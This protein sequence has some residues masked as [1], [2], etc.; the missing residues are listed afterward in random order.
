MPDI[1]RYAAFISYSSKDS[2]FA[3]RLHRKLEYYRIPHTLGEFSI[4]G[5]RNRIS[6]I[7]IDRAELPSGDLGEAIEAALR[8]SSA[9]IVVCS[10]NAAES[11]WVDKEIRY[12]RSLNRQNRIFAIIA[13]GEPNASLNGSPEIECFPPSL[14]DFLGGPDSGS[15]IVAGDARSGKDGFRNAWLKIV[16]GILGVNLGSLID[17]DREAIRRFRVILAL[18]ASAVFASALCG[19]LTYQEISDTAAMR[20]QA[21]LLIL[22]GRPIVAAPYAVAGL[23]SSSMVMGLIPNPEAEAVLQD[24]GMVLRL[25]LHI[26]GVFSAK[27]HTLSG[28]GRRLLTKN[29]DGHGSLYDTTTG[30]KLADLGR[31]LTWGMSE[32]GEYATIRYPDYSLALWD[33]ERGIKLS[34]LGQPGQAKTIHHNRTNNLIVAIGEDQAC[35]LWSLSEPRVAADVGFCDAV[36]STDVPARAVL[37]HPDKTGAIWSATGERLLDLSGSKGCTACDGSKVGGVFFALHNNHGVIFRVDNALVDLPS[38]EINYLSG[39][40]SASGE[41]LI[42]RDVR[43]RLALWNTRTGDLIASLG[44]AAGDQWRFS[45]KGT[46]V[47]ITKDDDSAL[48]WRSTD[49]SLLKEFPKGHVN[50]FRFSALNDDLLVRS[51]NSRAYLYTHKGVEERELP[52]SGHI[53]AAIFSED[54]T[55]IA[56]SSDDRPGYI[57]DPIGWIKVADFDRAGADN[58]PESRFSSNGNIYITHTVDLSGAVWDARTGRLIARLGG[59]NAVGEISVSKDGRTIVAVSS[60]YSASVWRIE[61]EAGKL[62]GSALRAHV[63]ANNAHHI[64]FPEPE[65]SDPVVETERVKR[66][67]LVGRS[68]NPCDWEGL[69]SASGWHQALRRGLGRILAMKD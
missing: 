53:S 30:R 54:G 39:G 47:L 17:R 13:D 56:V 1:F 52:L 29:G 43:N 7:F 66:R 60:G 38:Y 20:R 31:V 41:R 9:L 34:M 21:R 48:W 3:H 69:L 4:T 8:A 11:Q 28:N 40:L 49:G 63:C 61:T 15:T 62:A 24:T 42:T 37:R 5:K 68:H 67:L 46:S 65:A 50:S 23:P 14:R 22:D 19:M 58:G 16:A 59:P 64:R 32:T 25:A 10:P 12:F 2:A 27:S 45:P 18:S 55:R 26:P 35:R 51:T 6:P 36:S 44:T 57:W 33:L